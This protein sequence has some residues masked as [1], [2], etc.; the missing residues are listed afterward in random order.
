MKRH[1]SSD[2][3]EEKFFQLTDVLIK[4][5]VDEDKINTSKFQSCICNHNSDKLQDIRGVI[6]GKA[7]ETFL[8]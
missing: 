3:G 4:W 5:A 1:F 7:S 8:K 6:Y 2:G